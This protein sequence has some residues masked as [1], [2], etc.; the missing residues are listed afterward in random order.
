MILGDGII[1]VPTGL[2]T[3][4]LTAGGRAGGR[5]PSADPD[6]RRRRPGAADDARSA[7]G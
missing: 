3:A 7:P 2:V 1:A 5:A 4:E 6:D